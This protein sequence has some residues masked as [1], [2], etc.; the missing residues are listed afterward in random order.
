MTA[1]TLDGKI[2]RD[3]IATTLK[4]KIFKL[5]TK[6]KL[7][8]IQVGD[9][10]ES[11]TYIKQKILFAEKIG[12]IVEH[13]KLGEKFSQLDLEVL[14]ANLNS[15]KSIHGVIV[16]MPVPEH[17]DKDQIIDKINPKKDID[18]LTAT[19]LKKLF[20]SKKDGYTPATT[21]GVLTLL[22][23]YRI[24]ISGK[25]VT[26]VGRS[27]L[28]G[29]PTA[30]AFINRDATITVCHSHSKNLIEKTKNADILIVAAGKPK[31]ITNE[32]V[33]EN[34]III[35]VGINPIT[36]NRIRPS[37]GLSDKPES[38]PPKRKLVGDVD[39]K[40]VSKIVKAISPVPGGVGPMTV[41]SL[42]ENLLDAYEQQ[43]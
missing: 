3:K 2:V 20:E 29:K 37:N 30:L 18:G 33:S 16:Q 19:N 35:D 7:A 6:P 26:V 5:K 1:T 41:A 8:I 10:P 42:F 28:V 36:Q 12:A 4:K 9:L 24:P 15:D 40:E 25:N 21:K 11:N 27:S 23:F 14:V 32:H 34:Q 13:K 17:L 22:N 31:L 39:F 38:E 43:S